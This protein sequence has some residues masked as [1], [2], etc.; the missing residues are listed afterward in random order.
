MNAVEKLSYS[1]CMDILPNNNNR[2]PRLNN[3]R[4]K[5][6]SET[7]EDPN[8]N[9]IYVNFHHSDLSADHQKLNVIQ[10][11]A[12]HFSM[13]LGA[14]FHILVNFHHSDHLTD[15]QKLNVIQK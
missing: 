6:Q 4:P 3:R 10:K 13:T 12:F 5:T 11:S 7:T 2:R 1:V 15:H 8:L 14:F 9:N